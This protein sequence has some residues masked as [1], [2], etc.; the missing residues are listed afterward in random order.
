[1]DILNTSLSHITGEDVVDGDQL[2]IGNL[3]E[4]FHGLLEYIMDRIG[5]D[6]SS[7]ADEDIHLRDLEDPD[8]VTPEVIDDILERELGHGYRTERSRSSYRRDSDRSDNTDELIALGQVSRATQSGSSA[9]NTADVVA[10]GDS[11]YLPSSGSKRGHRRRQPEDSRSGNLADVS[12]ELHTDTSCEQQRR[13]GEVSAH[14]W[15]STIAPS[16]ADVSA[17]RLSHTAPT[18]SVSAVSQPPLNQSNASSM[19][20]PQP[21]TTQDFHRANPGEFSSIGLRPHPDSFSASLP[22]GGTTEDRP[23]THHT[24]T[25]HLYHHYNTHTAH[26]LGR[27]ST[28]FSSSL[29][30]PSAVA[31]LLQKEAQGHQRHT[32]PSALA[33]SNLADPY[34][35]S[36]SDG[37][38]RPTTTS[39]PASVSAT[40]RASD[41]YGQSAGSSRLYD[42][43]DTA[44]LMKSLSS[45][46]TKTAGGQVRGPLADSTDAELS[47][48]LRT[49]LNKMKEDAQL[50]DRLVRTHVND[51]QSGDNLR[52]RVTPDPAVQGIL[53]PGKRQDKSQHKVS[54]QK[55]RSAES[56]VYGEQ[57]TVLG[58]RG[59]VPGEE[60]LLSRSN[61]HSSSGAGRPWTGGED[62]NRTTSS[63]WSSE[64]TS[65]TALSANE[66]AARRQLSDPSLDQDGR[67]NVGPRRQENV[68]PRTFPENVPPKTFPENVPPRTFQEYLQK[69]YAQQPS[70]ASRSDDE[71]SYYSDGV[72]D[73]GDSGEEE[74]D[75]FEAAMQREVGEMKKKAKSV[76]F[77]DI[78]DCGAL[79]QMGGIRRSLLREDQRCRLKT[80]EQEFKKKTT[81]GRPVKSKVS[82][83][84][85]GTKS[86]LLPRQRGRTRSVLPRDRKRSASASPTVGTRQ[87][88]PD[89]D[90]DM[91]PWLL[92][93]FLY[94]VVVSDA[95]TDM[96]PWLLSESLYNVVVSDSDT[97]MLPW[98][99]SE[100]LYNVT[101]S[102]SDTDMLPWLLSEFPFLYLSPETVH[103]LWR[104]SS[105]QLELMS[106]AESDVQRKKSKAQVEVL[107]QSAGVSLWHQLGQL[108]EVCQAEVT[109]TLPFHY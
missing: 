13:R 3:L 64:T 20:M 99:L 102:D 50:V 78:L 74:E 19:S 33:S 106:R 84:T 89:A 40:Q 38:I 76:R 7:D 23:G 72:V 59:T 95:D 21:L 17:S 46:G 96:L 22:A 86:V 54:F 57:D 69:Y 70:H 14:T 100:F 105:R 6:I 11:R 65:S 94:N 109:C 1:M 73:Y 39:V 24:F 41:S 31:T 80:Q 25:H 88:A 79:G 52:P 47:E 97:D 16:S 53:S 42:T 98:L 66:L 67:R 51:V 61:G 81:G 44:E 60:G 48:A 103:D 63:L 9:N 15:P 5:S 12:S 34:V 91:L 35:S 26:G 55:A 2:A 28:D 82:S 10:L 18:A 101:V 107:V 8:L 62:R 104:K 49:T 71:S 108:F 77:D 27:P 43:V 32:L 29:P 36:L 56:S 58:E 90:I 30:V 93:E 83:K 75:G 4:V 45:Q 37:H 85:G 92:S 68:P 87:Q